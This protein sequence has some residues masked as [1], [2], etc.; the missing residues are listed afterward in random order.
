MKAIVAGSL[1]MDIVIYPTKDFKLVKDFI[2]IPF[3]HKIQVSKIFIEAGG[4]GYNVASTLTNFGNKVDL[5]G[6]VG[7]DTYGQIILKSMKKNKISLDCIKTITNDLTGFSLI[8]LYE[9][10]KTIVTY[11]GANNHLSE[12]DLIES[13]FRNSNIFIFTSM[14]SNQNVKFIDKA[15]SISKKYG[16]KIFCN[17]SI[18]MVE[19]QKEKL[20]EFIKNCDFVIMNKKEALKLTKTNNLKASISK[21]KKMC[22]GIPIITAGK[23]GCFAYDKKIKNFRAYDVEVIDTTGAGDTFTGAFIH[24][25]YLTEDL[26]YSL[27]FANA[28]AAIKISSHNRKIPSE[29]EVVKFMEEKS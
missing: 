6:A 3:D 14:V 17:P 16:L 1:V 21:L 26:E 15:I 10:E 19:Y 7:K 22:N 5:F 11:R 2:A 20:K 12:E 25:F 18:A 23:L 24:T 4:S 29:K 27:R 28:A 8:F 9:G 13:K